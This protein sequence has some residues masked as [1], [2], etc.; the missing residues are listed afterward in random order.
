MYGKRLSN[1]KATYSLDL[2]HLAANRDV[3]RN[4]VTTYEEKIILLKTK[5]HTLQNSQH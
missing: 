1:S 2:S 3:E 4:I 5:I